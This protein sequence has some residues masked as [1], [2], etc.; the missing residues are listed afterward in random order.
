M[1]GQT[2]ALIVLLVA[3][4]I[5]DLAHNI[6]VAILGSVAKVF[7]CNATASGSILETKAESPTPY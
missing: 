3:E 4:L 2:S 6:N 1:P 5:M 7:F